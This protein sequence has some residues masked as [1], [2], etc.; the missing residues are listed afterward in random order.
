MA[1]TVLEAL[2][3]HPFLEHF[4]PEYVE[5]LAAMAS[6]VNF[7]K[8]ETIFHEGDASSFFYLLVSGSV[9]LE[10]TAPGRTLRIATLCAGDELGWSS[11]TCERKQFQARTLEPVRAIAFDG[12]RLKHAFEEN[13]TFGFT[14]IRALLS[15]VARRLQ[16]TRMQ[17]VDMYSP[18]GAQ[19][20][21]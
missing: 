14:F 21:A 11:L 18:L 13:C 6:E 10:V 4:P 9:S 17:L 16:A 12:A 2:R 15:V 5:R 7:Q 8:Q 19:K 20:S 1:E 3:K